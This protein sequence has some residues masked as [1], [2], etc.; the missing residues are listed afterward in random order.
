MKRKYKNEKDI[1]EALR[2]LYS[3]Q[4]D[5]FVLQL[6]ESEEDD[7][8]DDEEESDKTKK[9]TK[10]RLNEF[11]QNNLQLQRELETTKKTLEKFKDID[12]EQY[13]KAMEA[14]NK[15]SSMEEGE[16]IKAG[17]IDE[18][19]QK[20]VQ[21]MKDDFSKQ[22]TAKDSIIN[23]LQS[24]N[25]TLK[26]TLGGITVESSVSKA[27]SKVGTLRKG[28]LPDVI[29]RAKSIFK[30]TDEGKMEAPG[31]L[32]DDEGNPMTM[33]K[34]AARL[35]EEAPFLFEDGAGGDSGGGQ[36]KDGKTRLREVDGKDPIAFGK[37]LE[38]IAK[39]EVVVKTE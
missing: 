38:K 9:S 5:W 6:E 26:S 17:K 30:V 25:K 33:E 18:V 11:R 15:I 12:P 14:Y 31:D 23:Q 1:P 10:K 32:F 4:G 21:T 8:G 36:R 7:G 37:N 27:I 34:W 35:T 13:A 2:S 22:V 20:R 3:K 28:A 19:V 29:N 24:E 16:L 39:G